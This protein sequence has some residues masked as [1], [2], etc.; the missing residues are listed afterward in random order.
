MLVAYL[1]R[2]WWL[3]QQRLVP[4]LTVALILPILLHTVVNLPLQ[5]LVVRSI[6]NIPYPEWAYPGLVMVVAMMAMIPLLYRELFDLRIHNKVLLPVTLS[7]GTKTSLI[8]AVM[9]TAIVEALVFVVFAM[10]IFS[11]LS[12]VHFHWYEYGVMVAYTVVFIVVVGNLIISL[13]LMTNRVTLFM[14]LILSL[15]ILVVFGSGLLVEFEFFPSTLGLVLRYLPTSMVA[16]GLRLML[17]THL[18]EWVP[19]VLPLL[20]GF[21]WTLLNGELLRRKLRQ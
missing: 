2:R 1:K 3:T 18:F 5:H 10:V 15:F 17:F 9:L 12:G 11:I 19:L 7:P 8:T 21:L 16:N 20:I 13:S 4:T 6:R 14:V